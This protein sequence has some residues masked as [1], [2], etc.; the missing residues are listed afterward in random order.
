MEEFIGVIA[1]ILIG[2]GC[3]Q[4][5]K[6]FQTPA[7]P[8]RRHNT[9]SASRNTGSNN[10]NTGSTN[11]NSSSAQRAERGTGSMIYM[12][13]GARPGQDNEFRFNYKKCGSG[14][15]AYI[16]KMPSLGSRD[17]G[18]GVTHRFHDQEGYYVCWNSTIPTL[19]QMQT[20][21]KI[22]ADNIQKYIQTGQSFG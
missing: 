19:K 2:C 14:W 17:S 3:Y 9:G 13:N 4:V 16:I 21:S 8:A 5:Y 1:L 12:A 6:L 20:T 10:R 11:R 7:R 15:R 22:W 18:V